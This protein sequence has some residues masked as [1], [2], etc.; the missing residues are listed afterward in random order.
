MTF[1]R[2]KRRIEFRYAVEYGDLD[3][4]PDWTEAELRASV[5]RTI[6]NLDSE[7]RQR[8][9]EDKRIEYRQLRGD[10]FEDINRNE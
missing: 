4:H 5:R 3:P 10:D 6:C 1:V 9:R 2:A 8:L 7:T